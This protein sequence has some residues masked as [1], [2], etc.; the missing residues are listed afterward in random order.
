MQM[1]YVCFL[2]ASCGSSQCG[3]ICSLLMLV[4]DENGDHM[5]EVYGRGSS[6]VSSI[7]ERR[8]MVLYEVPLSMSLLGFGMGTMLATFHMSGNMLGF[9][10][11]R[12]EEGLCVLGA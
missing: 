11:M 9:R 1:L 3:M 10:G 8:D 6:P 2:C 7:T 12:V 4:E 5:E